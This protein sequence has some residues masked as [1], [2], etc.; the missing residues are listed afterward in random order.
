MRVAVVGVGVVGGYFGGH[1]AH[2]GEDVTFVDRGK[3]SR[4]F[5]QP[6]LRWTTSTAAS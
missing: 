1:L 4:P 2:T 5:A 6:G 3:R